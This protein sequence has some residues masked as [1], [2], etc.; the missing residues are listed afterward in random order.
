MVADRGRPW[1]WDEVQVNGVV[2]SLAGG[3]PM[4]ILE[5]PVVFGGEKRAVS[6][7]VA[8]AAAEADHYT[9]AA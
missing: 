5:R 9:A 2:A 4:S 3:C 6:S 1:R 7:L 8:V